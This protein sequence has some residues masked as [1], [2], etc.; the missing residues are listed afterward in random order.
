MTKTRR[1]KESQGYLISKNQHTVMFWA[2]SSGRCCIPMTGSCC[3]ESCCCCCCCGVGVGSPLINV[4]PCIILVFIMVVVCLEKIL[5]VG[6][7]WILINSLFVRVLLVQERRKCQRCSI[8]SPPNASNNQAQTTINEEWDGIR[9]SNRTPF[10]HFFRAPNPL[11][12]R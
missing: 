6:K 8:C 1:E 12:C 10:S 9:A 4:E 7:R 3:G 11:H 5:G 2:A